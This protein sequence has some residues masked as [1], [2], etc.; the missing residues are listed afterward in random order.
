MVWC[1]RNYVITELRNHG[2]FSGIVFRRRKNEQFLVKY[3]D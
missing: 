1:R 3:A 2:K